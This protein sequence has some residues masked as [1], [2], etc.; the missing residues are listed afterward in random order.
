M[1]NSSADGIG[2]KSWKI[3]TPTRCCRC[4]MLVKIIS[5]INGWWKNWQL[6]FVKQL[7]GNMMFSRVY[8]MVVLFSESYR[9][10]GLFELTNI[11]VEYHFGK[12]EKNSGCTV[13][14]WDLRII[15]CAPWSCCVAGSLAGS[16]IGEN[17]L[18]GIISPENDEY[19]WYNYN[20]QKMMS[21][22]NWYNLNPILIHPKRPKPWS[23]VG[24]FCTYL[25]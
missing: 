9:C 14:S 1:L 13:V 6:V 7:M 17:S 21:I 25:Q 3:G 24:G 23:R 12:K 16:E 11:P 22:Y 8:M 5:W 10:M 19:N 2:C 18:K 15:R 20:H 4:S